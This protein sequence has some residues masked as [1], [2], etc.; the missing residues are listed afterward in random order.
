MNK[1]LGK[2]RKV[3]LRE[4]FKDEAR[5]FTPWL[6]KNID[7]LSEVVG[8]EISDIKKEQEVGNFNGDLVG[9]EVNSEYKVIIE[10]QLEPTN[11]DH[12]GKLVTYASGIGAKYVIWIAKKIREEH[13]QAIEWLNEIAENDI[14]FF[15]VEITAISIDESKPAVNFKLIVEPN[16]WTREV[17][18]KTEQIDERHRKYLQ[19]FARLVSE[20]EKIKPE[21]SHLTARPYSWLAFGAG[22]AGFRFV[23]AFRGNNQFD[24]ELYIDTGDKDETKSYFAE[25]KRF[26]PEVDK[27]ITNLKWE[28]L[29]DKRASRIAAYYKMPNSVKNLNEKQIEELIS[30]AIQQMNLFKKVFPQYIQRIGD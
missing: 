9:I 27:Q 24:V 25:L 22:I 4:I 2:I 21:W 12:L 8:I 18:Q 28:E 11:H 17:K 20:Y 5:D 13:Q 6:E 7:Q 16:A 29:S 23:W 19:F 14:S 30:W 1:N 15:G 3:D 10:N 26:Q